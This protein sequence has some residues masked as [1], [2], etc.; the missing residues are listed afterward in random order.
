MTDFDKELADLEEGI[1]G[2]NGDLK[3]ATSEARKDR[4]LQTINTR[5]ET[6]N[7]LL[8]EKRKSLPHDLNRP[9]D[10]PWRDEKFDIVG[11]GIG[12]AQLAVG[13]LGL[14]SLVI[15]DGLYAVKHHQRA[16]NK[17]FQSLLDTSKNK[18]SKIDYSSEET[19]MWESARSPSRDSICTV[20][21]NRWLSL[22]TID[23]ARLSQHCSERYVS[24]VVSLFLPSTWSPLDWISEVCNSRCLA[25]ESDCNH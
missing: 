17:F 9:F 20:P 3:T 19:C 10:I 16:T 21:P 24:L 6:L 8:D 15:G 5:R 1:K 14:G 12:P 13:A 4:L 11:H 7:R 2:Y 23:L 22:E 18:L 25:Q